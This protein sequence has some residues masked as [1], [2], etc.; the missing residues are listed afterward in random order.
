M[1]INAII[2]VES[3]LYANGDSSSGIKGG[4]RKKRRMKSSCP[5]VVEE[6]TD[7]ITLLT[8]VDEVL[9]EVVKVDKVEMLPPKCVNSVVTPRSHATLTMFRRRLGIEPPTEKAAMGTN[10][11][12]KF[13]ATKSTTSF[14]TL[15]RQSSES[16][17]STILP[18]QNK[19]TTASNEPM[20]NHRKNLIQTRS[21]KLPPQTATPRET[22]QPR[23][24][25][26]G[27]LSCIFKP[28]PDMN[29]RKEHEKIR[30]YIFCSTLN[31]E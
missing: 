3:I 30:A 22:I 26:R 10:S 6:E 11:K 28:T 17:S 20:K 8:D 12:E 25:A 5:N 29:L 4:R 14:R 15:H 16:I 31:G 13:V 19:R 2:R 21:T 24:K 27:E 18:S 23:K 7:L 9:E 1:Q